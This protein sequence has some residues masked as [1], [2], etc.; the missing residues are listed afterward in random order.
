[1]KPENQRPKRADVKYWNAK[2]PPVPAKE[3][4]TG[5]VDNCGEAKDD[6]ETVIFSFSESKQ[7]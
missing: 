2:S 5:E 7:S 3:Q 6:I 1:M 4:T